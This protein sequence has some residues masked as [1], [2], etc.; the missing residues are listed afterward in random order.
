MR[1]FISI[2][3]VSLLMIGC[4]KNIELKNS[5]ILVKAKGKALHKS[6]LEENIPSGL[7]TEDSI[8]AAEHYIRTWINE[9]ILYDIASKNINNKENIEQLVENYRRSLFI[10][11][12]EEQLINERLSK[13]IDD[14][15]LLDYYNK[16]KDKFKLERPLVKGLYLKVP[17]EAPQ[18]SEIRRLCRSTNKASWEKL[19]SLKL[20]NGLIFD[21]YIDSWIYFNNLIENFPG[22]KLYKEDFTVYRKIIEKQDDKFIYFLNITDCLLLGDNAPFEY[23]QNIVQEILINQRK[24]DFL[25]KTEDDLYRRALDKGEIQFYN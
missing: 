12:Y 10:Y 24:I 11:Q 7:S 23:A 2:I 1:Y 20:N 19:E 22:E 16:N 6:V 4:S 5:D 17:I 3:V 9:V 8:I 15:D 18:L 13:G 21:L 25:K 14:R